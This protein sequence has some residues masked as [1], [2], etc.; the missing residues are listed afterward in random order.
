MSVYILVLVSVVLAVIGGTVLI[1]YLFCEETY[2]AENAERPETGST[3][4]P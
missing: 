3:S 1:E 4:D 2:V